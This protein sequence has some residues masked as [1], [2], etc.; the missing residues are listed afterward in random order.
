MH[1]NFLD[2]KAQMSFIIQSWSGRYAEEKILDPTRTQT[3][4]L[5]SSS[6]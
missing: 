4:A 5:Q 1:Q 6:Q 2:Q 3:P